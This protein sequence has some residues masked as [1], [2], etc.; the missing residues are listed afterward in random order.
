MEALGVQNYPWWGL[1]RGCWQPCWK[2]MTS[3]PKVAAILNFVILLELSRH[4]HLWLIVS[5]C[6]LALPPSRL[7]WSPSDIDDNISCVIRVTFFFIRF[8]TLN[9][10]ADWCCVLQRRHAPTQRNDPGVPRLWGLHSLTLRPLT[11]V[12]LTRRSI[13]IF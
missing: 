7:Q 9:R 2:V 5:R 10:W 11:T 6:R 8:W 3:R 1:G 4:F 13:G 12:C